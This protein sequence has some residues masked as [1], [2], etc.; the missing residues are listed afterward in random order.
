ME[1][2][3]RT[4]SWFP[5]TFNY[6]L[7]HTINLKQLELFAYDLRSKDE[8]R[9]TSNNNGTWQSNDLDLNLHILQPLINEATKH[10]ETLHKELGYRE[11]LQP[12]IDNMWININPKGGTT[13]PHVHQDNILSGVFY[14]KANKD[15]GKIVFPHPSSNFSYHFHWKTIGEYN[16]KNSTFCSHMPQAGK[17]ILFPSYALHYV[18]PNLSDE[19]RISFAFNTKLIE[20]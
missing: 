2:N 9:V 11:D 4:E 14:V 18:E 13:N 15:S 3:M 5:T 16:E 7:L 6:G 1:N 10:F 17:I 19:D 8:G 12:V 20:R